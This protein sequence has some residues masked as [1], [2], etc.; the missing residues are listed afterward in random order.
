M[1]HEQWLCELDELVAAWKDVR[2]QVEWTTD[3]ERSTIKEFTASLSIGGSDKA[4]LSLYGRYSSGKLPPELILTLGLS[5]KKHTAT[6]E[7]LSFNPNGNH[8]NTRNAWSPSNIPLIKL[9]RL[10]HRYYPWAFNRCWPYPQKA[11]VGEYVTESLD[12][13]SAAISYMMKRAHIRGVVPPPVG[14]G[15]LIL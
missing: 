1:D 4:G 12:D 9:Q 6:L 13:T 15:V 14:Q 5:T 10:R 11:E 7:R 2:G 8:T 3:P